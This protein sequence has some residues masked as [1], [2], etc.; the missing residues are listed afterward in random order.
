MHKTLITFFCILMGGFVI[1]QTQ[2]DFAYY[3]NETYRLY[4]EARWDE[5]IPLALES[6]E[7]GHD[8]YY[9]RMRL[10]IA[11]FENA[12][13]TKALVHFNKALNFDKG[14]TDA[15]SYSYSCLLYLGRE[16]EAIKYFGVSG[17]KPKFFHSLYFEPGTKLS[18]NKASVRNS[19][20]IFLGLNHDLGKTV[21]LFHGYQRLG[22]DF[23]YWIPG[24]NGAGPGGS[25]STEYTY[26]VIQNEYYAALSFL[27][28]KGFYI[29]PAFHIQEVN[30]DNYSGNNHVFSIQLVK[31]LGNIKLYGGYYNSEI[32]EKNQQQVEG[33]L[34]FYPLGNSNL[35]L[36]SQA[37]NHYEGDINTLIWSANGGVKILSKTWLE[38]SLTSG[39]MLNYSESNGYLLYN[40]LDVIKNKWGISVNQYLGNHLLYLGYVHESKE[41]FITET[42]F[43]HHDLIIGFNLTF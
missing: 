35:Y 7:I 31:W 8:F 23:A 11:Y 26:T 5:L 15:K 1:G 24:G 2:K 33:G 18:D 21:T 25:S 42:P 22:A 27:F 3:N 16:K 34:V 29:T 30:S 43:A 12:N 32:N 20:Y 40:Q 13:Y 36:Q 38:L 9:I 17:T 19:R 41:E 6:I 10:G 14:S 37:T 39:D 4:S 28:A